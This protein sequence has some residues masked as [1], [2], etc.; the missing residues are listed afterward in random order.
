MINMANVL[1]IIPQN[2]LQQN[3]LKNRLYYKIL[4]CAIVGVPMFSMNNN[5]RLHKCAVIS[6]SAIQ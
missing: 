1:R 6:G 3:F 5:F 4:I 2:A